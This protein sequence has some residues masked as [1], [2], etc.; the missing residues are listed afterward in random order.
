[1]CLPNCSINLSTITE[2]DE[3]DIIKFGLKHKVDFIAV[4]F[5]RRKKDI[6][7]LRALLVK[8]DP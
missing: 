5:T 6:D 1:M 4:S 7:D 8:N 2:K 3:E